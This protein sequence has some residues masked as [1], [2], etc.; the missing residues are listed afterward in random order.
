[1]TLS[2]TTLNQLLMGLERNDLMITISQAA[3]GTIARVTS[4]RVSQGYL[5]NF[6][7]LYL[8]HMLMKSKILSTT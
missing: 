5:D 6:D 2:K 8:G 3:A 1:M 4:Y 7:R